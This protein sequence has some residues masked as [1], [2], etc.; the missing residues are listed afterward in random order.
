MLVCSGQ[1]GVEVS[2]TEKHPSDNEAGR[3]LLEEAFWH[4]KECL[5]KGNAF[6]MC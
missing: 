1:G 5:S 3:W 2:A 4:S 6:S